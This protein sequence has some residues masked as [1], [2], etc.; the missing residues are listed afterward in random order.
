MTTDPHPSPVEIARK[1]GSAQRRVVLS[2]PGDG[3]WGRSANHQAAKRLWYRNDIPLLIDHRHRTDNVWSL[4][5]LGLAV[6]AELERER[7]E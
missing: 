6:R 7:G 3:N 2:L 4:R 1:L 5:P